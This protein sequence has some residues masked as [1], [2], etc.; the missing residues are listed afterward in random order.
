M[1][2][3]DGG[4]LFIS[5]ANEDIEHV[6]KIRNHLEDEGFNP[7][8]FFLKSRTAPWT[9]RR[10]IRKEIKARK[11]FVLVDSPA[12]R[13]SKWVRWEIRCVN[14]NKRK[15]IYRVDI[16]QD[17][18]PQLKKV[19]ANTRIF[20]SYRHTP[21]DITL[22]KRL[23]RLF[24]RNDFQVWRDMTDLSATADLLHSVQSE[25]THS[26]IFVPIISKD[27]L[28]SPWCH[29]ELSY[30]LRS[31][32]IIRPIL[33]CSDPHI[34]LNALPPELQNTLYIHVSEKPSRIELERLMEQF[35]Q[36]HK[37]EIL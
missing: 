20:L 22:A 37:E 23:H 4:W 34:L 33:V 8:V 3:I 10:L 31:G 24:E 35:I 13:E 5:Y 27:W 6:R 28:D 2:Q 25:I 18:K 17:I 19:I 21:N 15:R 7:I 36:F 1:E 14:R 9:L 26:G 11:W 29:V 16:S 32:L 12:S 30:A